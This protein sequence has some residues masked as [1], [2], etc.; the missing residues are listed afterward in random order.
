AACALGAFHLLRTRRYALAG[1]L[2]LM[3]VVWL[4]LSRSTST[5]VD[6]KSLMITS[7]VV[8]LIA[9]AGVAALRAPGASL[10]ARSAMRTATTLV[11][12]LFAGG[13]LASDLA[14]YH[15]S[16]LAPTARYDELASLNGRFAGRGPTLFTDFDEYSLYQLRDLGVGGA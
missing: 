11:A 15:S 8:V 6:A 5:W 7:P 16:N 3:L 9:W 10:A 14:Q 1:W 12:L 2:A 4:V 13:I